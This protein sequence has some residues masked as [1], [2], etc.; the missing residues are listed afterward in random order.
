M[1]FVP[2]DLAWE[3]VT[4]WDDDRSRTMNCLCTDMYRDYGVLL[5]FDGWQRSSKKATKPDVS[6]FHADEVS[7]CLILA[8]LLSWLVYF[9]FLEPRLHLTDSKTIYHIRFELRP[10]QQTRV[11]NLYNL[12]TRTRSGG[13]SSSSRGTV[14]GTLARRETRGED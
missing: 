8:R 3:L 7:F 13:V 2:S 11:S 14:V 9:L 5:D 1:E 10:E 4:G 6:A 12:S